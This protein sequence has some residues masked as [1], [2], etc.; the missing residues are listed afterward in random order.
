MNKVKRNYRDGVF[1]QL[2]NDE[3]HIR[4]LYSALAD[5]DYSSAKVDIVT[6]EDAIFGE[7]KNDLAF[8]IDS[9][10]IVLTEQQSTVNP[11]MPFRMGVYAMREY[12]KYYFD[13]RI[14][15]TTL[16]KIPM[17]ELY[18]FYNGEE[19]QP[20]YQELK[21]SEAFVVKPEKYDT[22]KI[23]VVVKVINVNYEKGAEVLKK[24]KTLSE[25]SRFIAIV[26]RNK[27]LYESLQAAIEEA[28][29]EC[30]A[31]NILREFLEKNGGDVVSFLFQA[32]TRE[33]IEEIREKDGYVKGHQE[34]RKEGLKEGISLLK[35]ALK[36]QKEG[37]SKD[38][39]AAELELSIEDVEEMLEV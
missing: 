13:K 8:I 3:N 5:K 29:K 15:S 26:Y 32:L 14:Y 4:E 22:I 2:F 1:R 10:F 30:I 21:F 24:C 38:E 11:N 19:E 27:K 20:L 9:K 18:V 7:I 33:E 23:E 37:K 36:L 34:G 31:N 25:Y 28:I 6:L 39:I 12:E 35:A 16:V 17:P